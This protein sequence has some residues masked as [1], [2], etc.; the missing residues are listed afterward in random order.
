MVRCSTYEIIS[1][2][3]L[4]FCLSCTDGY[5]DTDTNLMAEKIA[6]FQ[7]KI[8]T[9]VNVVKFLG[10]LNDA[11]TAGMNFNGATSSAAPKGKNIG[12]SLYDLF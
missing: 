3:C 7:S 12:P 8:L 10:Q 9:H 5:T 6:F 4:T 11:N 2:M 1:M